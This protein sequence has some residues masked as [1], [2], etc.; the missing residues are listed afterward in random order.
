MVIRGVG[1]WSIAKL[2]GVMYGLIGA[3]IGA[4][5]SLLSLLGAAASGM[6][7]AMFGAAAIVVAPIVYGLIGALVGIISG[8]F[9][10]LAAAITGGVEVDA[11]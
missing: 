1:L 4:F 9:F 7:E 8:L 11:E 6:S 3:L 2:F 5:M 10:N